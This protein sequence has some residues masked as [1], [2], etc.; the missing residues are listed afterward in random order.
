MILLSEE[1]ATNKLIDA[2]FHCYVA[3]FGKTAGDLDEA[4]P[5]RQ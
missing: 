2:N 5:K 3:L 1:R 4:L